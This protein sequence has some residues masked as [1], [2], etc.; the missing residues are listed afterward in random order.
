MVGKILYICLLRQHSSNLFIYSKT[1]KLVLFKF[2]PVVEENIKTEYF[3]NNK[4][5]F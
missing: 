1:K 2:D 4:K 3:I 5:N